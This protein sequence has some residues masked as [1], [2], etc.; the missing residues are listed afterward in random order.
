MSRM[1]RWG[2]KHTGDWDCGWSPPA[3]ESPVEFGKMQ[4]PGQA[5]D[6]PEQETFWG[7]AQDAAR[8]LSPS[9]AGL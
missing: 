4:S 1:E 3:R 7:W 8:R 2:G 5:P 6:L 9:L